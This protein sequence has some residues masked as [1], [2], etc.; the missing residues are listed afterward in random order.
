MDKKILENAA[1]DLHNNELQLAISDYLENAASRSD[2]N[3]LKELIEL[4]QKTEVIV[5]VAFPPKVDKELLSRML[6]GEKMEKGKGI[7][8]L[9]VTMS[10]KKGNKFAP[11]FTSREM[12]QEAKDFPFM[13]RVSGEQVVK[14]VLNEK[15]DLTGILL[16]PQSKPF[17]LRKQA[18]TE[19]FSKAVERSGQ[20]IRKVSKQ[21]FDV[22]AR[23]SVEKNLIPKMLFEKKAEFVQQLEEERE[24]FLAQLYAKP[25]GEKVPSPYTEDDFSLM[26]LDID[27]RTTAFC[28]ELPQKSVASK[29]ALSAY[30]IWNPQTQDAYYY[31]IEKGQQGGDNVLCSISPDGQHEE[32]MTAP[33]TGSEL[34]AVLDLIREEE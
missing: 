10:D 18:F 2:L 28:I 14:T 22:L 12:V 26:V 24:A 8:M 5:P 9:P 31:L 13:I 16:D 32:L 20:Q 30:I 15:L 6:R 23:N 3:R 17:L 25:Y 21:E 1:Y 7:P 11:A 34:S 4:F 29:I 27:E 33:P 19:D